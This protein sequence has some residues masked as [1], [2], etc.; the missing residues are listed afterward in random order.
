MVAKRRKRLPVL[1]AGDEEPE[2]FLTRQALAQARVDNEV[3]TLRDVQEVVRYLRCVQEPGLRGRFPPPGMVLL[4]VARLTR[5]EIKVIEW[6]QGEPD[7]RDTLP[8][9]VLSRSDG[10]RHRAAAAHVQAQKYSSNPANSAASCVWFR[11]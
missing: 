10:P 2:L 11:T 3:I 9:I 5:A 4:D 6:I 1:L 7:W 8:V